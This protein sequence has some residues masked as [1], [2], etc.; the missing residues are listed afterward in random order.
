MWSF[1]CCSPEPPRDT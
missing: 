1:T